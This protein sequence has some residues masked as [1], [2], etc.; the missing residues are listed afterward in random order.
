MTA[1]N[2]QS[3]WKHTAHCYRFLLSLNVYRNKGCVFGGPLQLQIVEL[4]GEMPRF[5]VI[6]KTVEGRK[7]ALVGPSGWFGR[8]RVARCLGVAQWS[9]FAARCALTSKT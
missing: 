7:A 2:V 1:N 3:A 5:N 4:R 9:Y 6:D 8:S